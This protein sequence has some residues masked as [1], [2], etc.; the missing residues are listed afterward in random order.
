MRNSFFPFKLTLLMCLVFVS[1]LLLNGCSPPQKAEPVKT[2]SIP[3]NAYDPA[4]WGK[5]YPLEYD[6]YMATKDPKPPLSKYK[7]GF[8]TDKIIYDKLSEFP[9]MA[10]LFNGWG[11][12]VEYNEPRGHYY[13]LIDQL[14]VDPSRVKAGGACL[15]CKSPYVPQ[16]MQEMGSHYYSDPYLDVHAK[17]PK[18]AQ[19][20]GVA[21]INCHNNQDMSLKIHQPPLKKALAELGLDYA[22]QPRQEMRSLV[23][24]QCHVTYIVPK[25]ADNKSTNVFFPWQGSKLGDIPV[26]NIIKVLRSDPS[27]GEWKQAVTGFKFGFIRH[28]EFEFFSRNSVHWMAK[29]ACAD[30]H[31]PYMRVGANKISSHNVM[32]PLKDDMKACQQCHTESPAWLKEQV[33]AI[34]DRTV[35]L[36]NRAG[37]SCAVTA[38]VF[39]QIHR[40]QNEGKT[41][42]ADLY[43]RAKDL[44]TEAFYRVIYAG[45]ENSV[46]FHNPT[47]M[48]RILGDA[49]AMASKAEGL[50]RQALGKEGIM[51]ASDPQLEMAKYLTARGSKHLNFNPAFEFK[52]PFG[53][54]D[55]LV[56]RS[57]MGLP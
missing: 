34:Q 42:D 18:E 19:K 7:K 33:I 39:E 9:F 29:V 3:D 14:E 1:L 27:H 17:I 51:P 31:M 57:S 32:S 8:D 46:G 12:G 44:Y 23:C 20:L 16:L 48:G 36:L 21:C 28:P 4:V 13:M 50:L 40:H 30:C 43:D 22:T 54:Q 52:D 10:L 47:E 41:F 49:I 35:S 15:T 26:E 55:K 24:A 5:V 38:K 6:S 56:S 11:F 2:A 37:Y 25:D 45:A 53:I